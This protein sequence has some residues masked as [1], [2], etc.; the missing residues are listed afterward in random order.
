MC[1]TSF[2]TRGSHNISV[3]VTVHR[4]PVVVYI[5]ACMGRSIFT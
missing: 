4:L 5:T 2:P 3:H 1:G